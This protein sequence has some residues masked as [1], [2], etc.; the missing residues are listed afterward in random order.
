MSVLVKVME[1]RAQWAEK[2]H[3]L[4]IKRKKVTSF[5]KNILV[6]SIMAVAFYYHKQIFETV[7][8]FITTLK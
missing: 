4:E 7:Q 1:E 6:L 8:V 3:E 5:L 2:N